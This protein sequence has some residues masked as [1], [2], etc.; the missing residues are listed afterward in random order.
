PAIST[1]VGGAPDVI[2]H[3]QNGW[4]IPPDNLSSLEASLLELLG[5]AE[6]R[7]EMGRNARQDIVADYSLPAVA[8]KLRDLYE[9]LAAS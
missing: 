4:L 5:D 2:K 3:G 7:A 8:G 1:T 6:L 9:Q